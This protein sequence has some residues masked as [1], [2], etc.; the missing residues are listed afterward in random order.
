ML[1]EVDRLTRL[2]GESPDAD[3]G[4]SGRIQPALEVVDLSG[5]GS[6]VSISEYS[7]RRRSR[8]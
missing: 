5:A 2:S 6:V 7:L 3:E 8:A 4:E 1:E